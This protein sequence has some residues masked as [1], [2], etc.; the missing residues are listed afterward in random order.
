MAGQALEEAGFDFG[1]FIGDPV[2]D[3]SCVD[4]FLR[5]PDLHNLRDK[6]QKT[7]QRD[8]SLMDKQKLQMDL[9]RFRADAEVR[10][11]GYFRRNFC[12]KFLI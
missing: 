10:V 1:G 5:N 11:D 8:S 4:Q 2:P 7:T 6:V 9:S 3:L 12:Y